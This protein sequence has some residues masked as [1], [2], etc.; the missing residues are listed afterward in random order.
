VNVRD[1]AQA[2]TMAMR[3]TALTLLLVLALVGALAMRTLNQLPDTTIYLVR[4][5]GTTMTLEP[6]HRRLR[7]STPSDAARAA[8]D[9]LVRGPDAGES[10]RGLASEVP[11]GT[12][13]RAVRNQNGVLIVDLSADAVSG[14]GSASMQARLAQLTYTL[15][16]PRGVEAVELWVEGGRLEAWGGEGVMTSWPWRRPESG[17]MPRW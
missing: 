9:A 6:V 16:Q 1:G 7:P 3:V 17:G 14:G 5:E 2:R 15:T 8:V 13:V 4:S 10:A 12:Q 11:A